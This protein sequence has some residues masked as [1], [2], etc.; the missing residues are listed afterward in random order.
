MRTGRLVKATGGAGAVALIVAFAPA[1]MASAAPSVSVSCASGGAGLVAAV[2]AAN[3]AGGGTIN[4]AAGCDY[5]LTTADNGENGLPIVTTV[6][7]V[8]G[9]VSR[10]TIGRTKA[11][12]RPS[13]IAAT[14]SVSPSRT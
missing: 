10:I 14:R 1:T 5:A 7:T 6:I 4:L 2:N 12:T 9:N 8:N 13:R 3:A 11:L